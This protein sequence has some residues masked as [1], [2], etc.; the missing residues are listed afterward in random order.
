MFLRYPGNRQA[1]VD[2]FRTLREDARPEQVRQIKAPTLILWGSQDRLIPSAN[3]NWF[4]RHLPSS[5]T[6]VYPGVGHLPMEEAPD[7]SSSDF[8]DWVSSYRADV[9]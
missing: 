3:S 2:Q 6:R 5:R 9:R 1:M 8:H 4:A 7:Q